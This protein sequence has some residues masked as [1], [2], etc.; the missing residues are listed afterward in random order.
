VRRRRP[1]V[2]VNFA[3]SH[4]GRISFNEP[5]HTGAADVNEGQ[6]HDRW[7]MGLLRARADAVM[8]GDGTLRA[9]PGHVWT[10][11][12][13]FPGDAAAFADLR[14]TEGR[15]AVPRL[16]VL[17]QT[18]ELP[19]GA[20]AF[21]AGLPVVVATTTAGARAARALRRRGC[22]EVVAL[23]EA[24]VDLRAL[25]ALLQRRFGVRTLLCEGGARTYGALLGAGCVDDEF[26]TLCPLLVGSGSG[27]R[28]RPSLVEGVTFRPGRAPHLSLRSVR[29]AEDYLFLASRLRR[30]LSASPR[31]A[32][33]PAGRRSPDARP[34]R[35]RAG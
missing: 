3:A 21:R 28:P 4:D 14:R 17:S 25:L 32:A 20:E 8:V 24:S 35:P 29:Q 18:G 15:T 7:L 34:S 13:I 2:F 16:V 26:L 1:Y 11:E 9:S 19:A 23:G 12:Y 27:A 30:G 10:P 31:P 5:G 33:S 6:A 22:V